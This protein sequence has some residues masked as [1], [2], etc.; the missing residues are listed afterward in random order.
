VTILSSSYPDFSTQIY[1]A[2][3]SCRHANREYSKAIC[4]IQ[5]SANS[6]TQSIRTTLIAC[7]LFASFELF[8]DY[9]ETAASQIYS[10]VRLIEEL[11][12]ERQ[13][14]RPDRQPPKVEDDI[15]QAFGRLEMQAT[16]YSDP[17][18]RET[19]IHHRECGDVILNGMPLF[20]ATL[21]E[22]RTYLDLIIRQAMHWVSLLHPTAKVQGLTATSGLMLANGCIVKEDSS[23]LPMAPSQ[24]CH[25]HYALL[26]MFKKWESAFGPVWELAHKSEALHL[27]IGSSVLRLQYLHA[28]LKQ[29]TFGIDTSIYYGAYS[30]ELNEIIELARVVLSHTP[31]SSNFSVDGVIIPPLSTVAYRYRDRK[32]RKEAIDLLHERPIKEGVWSGNIVGS[33]MEWFGQIE[34]DGLSDDVEYVPP[35][36]VVRDVEWDFNNEMRETKISCLQPMG[37]E[38]WVRRQTV[39]PWTT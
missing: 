20:F 19:H 4:Q 15:L 5:N 17:R 38:E 37:Q 26:D 16:S 14:P 6:G 1:G 30:S 2:V 34:E 32:L 21:Q 28:Y 23:E 9:P 8:N 10:G 7:L 11:M 39:I 31:S 36:R 25:E 24:L 18:D 12:A 22:A 13:K 29:V 27:Y 3:S 33:A 35:N